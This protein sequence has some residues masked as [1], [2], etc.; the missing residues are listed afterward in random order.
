MQTVQ[1]VVLC[2]FLTMGVGFCIEG[3][4]STQTKNRKNRE[5][6][7][8]QRARERE[9]ADQDELWQQRLTALWWRI[10]FQAIDQQGQGNDRPNRDGANNNPHGNPP[11]PGV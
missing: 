2:C 3:K 1:S 11:R 4:N 9:I 10:N 8:R 6:N 5:R 7:K